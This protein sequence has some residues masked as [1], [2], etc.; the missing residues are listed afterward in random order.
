MVVA[1]VDCGTPLAWPTGALIV[2]ASLLKKL[3]ARAADRAR[4]TD[5]AKRQ[6][7]RVFPP[8]DQKTVA[9]AEKRLGFKL[10]APLR[11]LYTRVGNGGFG[12]A[13]G[14]LGLVGGAK[15]EER[16][17]AVSVYEVFRK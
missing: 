8:I 10:P 12:P 11:V 7:A 15:N 4:A 17:D 16:R 1:G 9:A 14:L 5:D 2:D 3:R 13:Y 6:R